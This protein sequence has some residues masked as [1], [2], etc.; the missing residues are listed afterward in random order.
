MK[1]DFE[2]TIYRLSLPTFSYT[3]TTSLS[4]KGIFSSTEK[5]YAEFSVILWLY[6]EVPWSEAVLLLWWYAMVHSTG[7]FS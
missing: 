4:N 3:T 5:A 2:H 7:T 6:Y 1:Q